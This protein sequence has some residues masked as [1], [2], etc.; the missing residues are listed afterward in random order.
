PR[1]TR[2]VCGSNNGPPDVNVR[3]VTGHGHIHFAHRLNRLPTEPSPHLAS[4]AMTDRIRERLT[5]LRNDLDTQ[6]ARTE[7]AEAESKALKQTLLEKENE[8]KSL[9]HNL[10]IAEEKME[11]MEGDLKEASEKVRHLDVQAEQAERAVQAAETKR[12]EW[13]AKY[14]S[15][16][17]KHRKVKADLEELERTMEGL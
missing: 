8:I 10:A 5:N 14:E 9:S 1:R 11:K 3:G 4:S 7:A 2:F 17:E 15:S 16:E 12:D 13:E 6:I